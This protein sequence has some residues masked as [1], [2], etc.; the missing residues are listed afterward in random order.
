MRELVIRRLME[1]KWYDD[2]CYEVDYFKEAL[3]NYTDDDLLDVYVRY[4]P[5]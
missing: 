2:M 5:C 4:G 1:T 3:E